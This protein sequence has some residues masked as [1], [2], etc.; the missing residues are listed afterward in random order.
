MKPRIEADSRG[1]VFHAF[2]LFDPRVRAV[3]RLE[4]VR[5]G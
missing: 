4:K 5:L 2:F 3:T 1:N